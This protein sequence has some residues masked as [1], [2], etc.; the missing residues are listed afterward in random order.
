MKNI[1]FYLLLIFL[2]VYII[3]PWDLHPHFI[4]DLIASGLL[5]RLW[6][7]Y[8][9]QKKQRDYYY[10]Q[11]QSQ[12]TKEKKPDADLDLE[13][14]YRLLGV[15]PNASWKEIQRA[16]K[17]KI[18]KSHPD[19]VSHLSEELQKKAKELTLKLNKAIDIIRSYKRS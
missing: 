12:G 16:Y 10:S 7:Q 1:I 14:A 9:K 15:S 18:A 4:D 3:S 5:F 17:E 2:I 6:Y 19:K 13:E 11:S 8:K